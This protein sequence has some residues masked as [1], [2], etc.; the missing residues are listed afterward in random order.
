MVTRRG[1]RRERSIVKM[2]RGTWVSVRD[3]SK[4]LSKRKI[5]VKSWIRKLLML[6]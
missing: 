1:G 2:F 3:F 6:M 4:F 5:A